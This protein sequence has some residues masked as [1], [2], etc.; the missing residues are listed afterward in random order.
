MKK[1]FILSCLLLWNF[2]LVSAI[3]PATI[4][5]SAPSQQAKKLKVVVS[6]S[7]LADFAQIIGDDQIELNTIVPLN[8]DPHIYQPSPDASTLIS[9]ADL[10]IINGLEFEGWMTRLFDAAK[11]NSKMIIASQGVVP[12]VLYNPTLSAAAPISDPHAWH[13]VHQAMIYVNNISRAFVEADP[14]HATLYQQRAQDYLKCLK[15]L[16]FWIV[17]TFEKIARDRLKMI[18]A[19]DAFGYFAARYGLKIY[20]LQGISTE[21]EPS[22]KQ[23]ADLINLIKQEHIKALFVENMTNHR[24]LEQVADETQV[25]IGGTLYTDSLSDHK[26]SAQTYLK[27]MKHNVSTIHQAIQKDHKKV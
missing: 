23:V 6:F 1:A 10:V 8:S 5:A 12:R 24:L 4:L 22:A 26:G 16:D 2:V 21:S 11:S 18:T 19:H 25:K 14:S 17:R 20:A 27:M 15:E 9:Q 7:I 13:D 3:S